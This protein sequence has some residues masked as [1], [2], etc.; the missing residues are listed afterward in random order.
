MKKNPKES[1]RDY[2]KRIKVEKTKIVGCDDSITGAAFQKELL[3]DHP[4]FEEMIMKEDLTLANSFALAEK[5][6]LWDEARQAEKTP[7]QPRKEL[8]V[9]QRKEDGKQSSKDTS[10]LD[11]TKYC[12]FHQSPGHTTDD[13]YTWKNYLEKLVK[14]G[15]V[16]R[17][18]DKTTAQPRRNTNDEETLPKTIRIDG[19]FVESEHLGAT[20]NSKKRK[21]QQALLVSQVQAVNTQPGPTEQ[22]AEGVDFLHDN[23]L[24]VPVQL[25]NVIIDRMMVDNGSAVNLLQLSV[26]QKMGLE[27]IIIR[28]ADVLTRFNGHTSTVIGYITLD[29]KTPLVVLKQTFMIVSDLSPYNKI[30]G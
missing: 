22:D 25:A 21:I 2:V 18:L 30:F 11:H 7:K 15:K 28:R 19:V 26:I 4:L 23:A 8:V 24:V 6:A 9:A 17:Y 3:A 27:N 12:A 5:Y 10:K 1:L 29:V 20:N 16:D 14:E 13:Y